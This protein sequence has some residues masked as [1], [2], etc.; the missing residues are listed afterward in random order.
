MET[1][2]VVLGREAE[3]GLAE[4]RTLLQVDDAAATT[5]TVAPGVVLVQPTDA[6]DPTWWMTRLGGS[7]LIARVLGETSMLTADALES[8][9]PEAA[10]ELAVSSPSVSVPDRTKLLLKLKRLRPGLRYRP[11]ADAYLASGLSE[12]LLRREDGFELLIVR[13]ADGSYVLAQVVA[14]QDARAWTD[15]DRG[16]PAVDPVAGMLPPKLARIMVN[17]AEPARPLAKPTVISPAM[18]KATMQSAV[19][20]SGPVIASQPV[21]SDHEALTTISHSLLNELSKSLTGGQPDPG[22]GRLL[23]PFSGSGQ[24]PIE[25]WENSWNVTASD[26]D[27]DAVKRTSENL[28]WAEDRYYQT[29]VIERVKNG[30]MMLAGVDPE[31]LTVSSLP[32]QFRSESPTVFQADVAELPEKLAGQQFDA[33]VAEPDLGPALRQNDPAPSPAILD[34]V[35]NTVAAAFNAGKTLLRPGGRM[36]IVIPIIAGIRIFDRLDDSVYSGYTL[37]ESLRYARPDARVE[38]E[39]F[40]FERKD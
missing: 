13:Q 22:H 15:R 32:P 35:T 23:D 34:R 3:L 12:R 19:N 26:L 8:F 14:V 4:L 28:S 27:A 24:I 37:R 40:V 31:M 39:I 11:N 10:R 21:M 18:L 9:L 7:R 17:L 6:F 5:S 29:R 33:I 20:E 36:V 25:A 30:E 2:L 1:Y 16:L 38:R